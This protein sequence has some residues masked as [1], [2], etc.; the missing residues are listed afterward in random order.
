[1]KELARG[2]SH[3]VVDVVLVREV[4]VFRREILGAICRIRPSVCVPDSCPSRTVRAWNACAATAAHRASHRT[5]R[6]VLPSR[7]VLTNASAI[8]NVADDRFGVYCADCSACGDGLIRILG[9]TCRAIAKP[10]R[11]TE[12]QRVFSYVRVR[13]RAAKQ[14]DRVALRIPTLRRIVVSEVVVVSRP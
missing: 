3:V 8:F 7:S 11:I 12:Q 2:R 4:H 14:P 13:A 5:S 9:R 1:V 6:E 10:E